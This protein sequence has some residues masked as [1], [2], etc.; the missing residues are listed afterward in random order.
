MKDT[1]P[2]NQDAARR[3]AGRAFIAALF[4]GALD[5]VGD[6]HGEH[7]AL[8]HLLQ[9]L[10]YDAAGDHPEG[11]RLVFVGD[12]TDRGPDSVSVVLKVARLVRDGRAQCIAGNHE[13]NILRKAPKEGNGWVLPVNHDHAEGKFRASLSALDHHRA[14]I[15]QF[16]ATL[17]LALE[18]GDLRV[19]HACWHGPSIEALRTARDAGTVAADERFVAS[20]QRLL[21]ESGLLEAYQRERHEFGAALRDARAAPPLLPAIAEFGARRQMANPVRVLTSGIERPARAPFYS[22]GR[23]R[24]VER[25][26]WWQEYQDPI[27]VVF[28]HFWRRPLAAPADATDERSGPDLFAGTRFDQWLGPR[29]NAF[30]VDYSIGRRFLERERRLRPGTSTRLGA[31]RWPEAELVFDDG[32]RHAVTRRDGSFAGDGQA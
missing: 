11:R 22:G 16:F 3:G 20:S 23:W 1:A 27:P 28:G 30:C 8:D 13:L 31:I 10:G 26:A 5:L 19:V 2:V 29:H 21:E 9:A 18:R 6:V 17:P 15:E 32:T 24:M 12:L 7:E 4:D 14:A 25:V